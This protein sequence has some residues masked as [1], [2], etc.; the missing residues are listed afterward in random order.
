MKRILVVIA[1]VGVGVSAIVAFSGVTVG[2]S[3]E[4][5]IMGDHQVWV[6]KDHSRGGDRLRFVIVR[7]WP[8]DATPEQKILD[9]RVARGFLGWPLVRDQDGRII[10]VGSDGD[11]YFFEGEKLKRMRVRRNEHDD[12]IGLGNSK[13][14]DEMWAFFKRFE[15]RTG[16]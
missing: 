7:T 10:P 4:W 8:K 1:V 6:D 3:A 2:E 16:D 14:L 5:W 9:R 12:T 11:V 13:T 15:V